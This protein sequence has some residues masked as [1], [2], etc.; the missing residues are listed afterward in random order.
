MP[1]NVQLHYPNQLTPIDDNPED[2][3]EEGVKINILDMC[4]DTWDKR[5]KMKLQARGSIATNLTHGKSAKPV[6]TFEEKVPVQFHGYWD[7]FDKKE[8]NTLPA[9]WPWGHTIDLIPDAKPHVGK[10]YPMSWDEQTALNEFLEENLH[11]GRIQPSKSPW[12]SPFFFGKKKDTTALRPI[13]DYQKLND[14]MI[15]N[16]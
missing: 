9:W 3:P 11:F 1:R 5:I 15:K 4:N 13:Q 16:W 12:A 10:I 8:F 2:H 6:L 7:V 14:L